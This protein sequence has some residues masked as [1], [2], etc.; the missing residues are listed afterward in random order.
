MTQGEEKL[1]DRYIFE[2]QLSSSPFNIHSFT[3]HRGC[4]RTTR[5]APPVVYSNNGREMENNWKMC[6]NN[7]PRG[8][9]WT[10]TNTKQWC[11]KQHIFGERGAL[12]CCTDISWPGSWTCS[13]MFYTSQACTDYYCNTPVKLCQSLRIKIKCKIKRVFLI[14]F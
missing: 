1:P 7:K 9:I 10:M 12:R 4:G 6:E 5:T 3:I 2:E 14:W 11:W 8:Q 13:T